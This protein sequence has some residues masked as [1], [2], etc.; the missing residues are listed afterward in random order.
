MA[1]PFQ[2]LL[3]SPD[4]A[5]RLSTV[6]DYL[7]YQ[8]A[9]SPAIKALIWLI[10]AREYDCNFLWDVCCAYAKQAGIQESVLE[11]IRD[12]TSLVGLTPE[13]EVATEFC[14]QLLR[15]NHHVSETLYRKTVDHFGIAATVQIA[16]TIGYF[17]MFAFV[18]NAFEIKSQPEDA[19]LPV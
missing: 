1:G 9:I 4:M 6:G 10:S 16:A 3:H 18:A 19:G 5:D 15:G 17:V 13:Q 8:S 12:Q 2:V 7:V 14:Y 11:A